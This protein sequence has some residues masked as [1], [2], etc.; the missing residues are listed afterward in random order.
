MNIEH[1][2]K[3]QSEQLSTEVELSD[4]ELATVQGGL[5][6]DLCV[7]GVLPNVLGILSPTD[8]V[9]ANAHLVANV[10]DLVGLGL[11]AHATIL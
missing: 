4:A 8:V 6:P 11:C 10:A 1:T 7:P 5:C 2:I 3:A 9:N